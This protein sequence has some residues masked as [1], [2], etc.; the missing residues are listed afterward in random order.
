MLSASLIRTEHI[1]LASAYNHCGSCNFR[2]R[3]SDQWHRISAIYELENTVT[4]V[5]LPF[6][7][8]AIGIIFDII[9]LGLYT[10][11]VYA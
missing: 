2:I 8:P 9:L 1:V 7:A 6:S 5:C 10:N 11:R 4:S 3:H